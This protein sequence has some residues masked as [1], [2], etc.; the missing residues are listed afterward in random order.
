MLALAANTRVVTLLFTKRPR[1]PDRLR[2]PDRSRA[3]FHVGIGLQKQR[4]E[5]RVLGAAHAG[6]VMAFEQCGRVSAMLAV[7][8]DGCRT[9]SVAG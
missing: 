2:A 5:W 1:A 4:V 6:S 3:R 7:L 8:L 9:A